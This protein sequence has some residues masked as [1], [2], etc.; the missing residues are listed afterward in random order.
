MKKSSGKG[1]YSTGSDIRPK[2]KV[3]EQKGGTKCVGVDNDTRSI[4][5]MGIGIK[6]NGG[7]GGGSGSPESTLAGNLTRLNKKVGK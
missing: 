6:P 5:D 1:G 4:L 3:H 2:G 7:L